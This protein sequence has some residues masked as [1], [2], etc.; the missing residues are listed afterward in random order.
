MKWKRS[1]FFSSWTPSFTWILKCKSD[2][3][4]RSDLTKRRMNDA[5]EGLTGQ[6]VRNGSHLRTVTKLLTDGGNQLL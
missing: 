3:D 4:P 6:D 1:E 2:P 5:E